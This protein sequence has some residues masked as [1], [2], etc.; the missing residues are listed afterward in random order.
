MKWIAILGLAL[1][2]VPG[3]GQECPHD[4]EVRCIDDINR[5]YA[6]CDEAA[7][8]KG[9]DIPVDL[10]CVQFLAKSEKECWPCICQVAKQ[11]KWKIRG[12]TAAQ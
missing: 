4:L 11:N 1:V 10:E 12:C 8:E 9:R 5:A 6:E 3:Q 2:A 7:K